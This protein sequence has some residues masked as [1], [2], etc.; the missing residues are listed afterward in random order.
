M[1]YSNEFCQFTLE[2][3]SEIQNSDVYKSLPKKSSKKLP[4]KDNLKVL[5]NYHT[6]K[7]SST[8]L[9]ENMFWLNSLKS[10]GSVHNM[11]S[12]VGLISVQSL[13]I[14]SA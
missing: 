5:P 11:T 8:I 13:I 4:T 1:W 12:D 10:N 7:Q 3:F 2:N 6:S 14:S 9:I